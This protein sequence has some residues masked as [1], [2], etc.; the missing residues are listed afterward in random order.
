MGKPAFV[1]L[2]DLFDLILLVPVNF[3]V[4]SGRLFLLYAILSNGYSVLLK[5]TMQC[6][7]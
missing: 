4:M 2:L 7:Q 1:A 6:L 5:D 3:L